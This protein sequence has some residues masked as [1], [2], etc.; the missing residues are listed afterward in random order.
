LIALRP[1]TGR[2]HQLRAHLEAIGT[3]ILGDG[4]YGGAEARIE[5]APSTRLHLH[6]RAIRLKLGK[7]VLQAA[8]MPPSGFMETLKFFGL[9]QEASADP[10]EPFQS[11]PELG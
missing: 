6:A 7:D 1:R 3:P 10:F 8:A 11:A 4:K 9:E 5:G 2:T